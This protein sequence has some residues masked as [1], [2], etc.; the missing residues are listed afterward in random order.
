[1]VAVHDAACHDALDAL[2]PALAAN[3]NHAATVPGGGHLRERLLGEGRLYLAAL[4]VDVLELPRK[5]RCLG[6]VARHEQVDCHVG[7]AHATGRVEARDDREGQRVRGDLRDILTRAGRKGHQAGTRGPSQPLY[8]VGDDGAVLGRKLHH[9]REGAQGGDV[10]VRA[11]DVRLPQALAQRRQ[12]LERHAR[13]RKIARGTVR[14]ELGVRHGNALGHKVCGLVVV[15][16]NHVDALLAKPVDLVLGSD[17]VVDGHDEIGLAVCQHA[18]ECR[19]GEAV[20][21]A[22]AMRDVGAGAPAQFAQAQRE[23]AGGAHAI[24]VEVA[25]DGDVLPRPHCALD[26][27]CRLGHARDDE[28]I[29][30]VAPERGGEKCTGLLNVGKATGSKDPR[31]QRRH[32]QSVSKRRLGARIRVEDVPA[33]TVK[34]AGH[35]RLPWA[36]SSRH[37]QRGLP[38]PWLHCR[39]LPRAWPTWARASSRLPAAGMPRR[40]SS[41]CP[42]FRRRG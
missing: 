17:A 30:P 4:P 11:P 37:R 7:G 9:V 19:L 8:T 33:S 15:G 2:V 34:Q 27:V 1:M 29:C 18:V 5:H 40:S 36:R 42:G 39:T 14:R 23:D 35:A 41:R 22:K 20:A 31:H 25:K 26:A 38:Q 6:G 13:A 16:H 10:G 24:H 28:R 21:L 3:N 12:E 32:A